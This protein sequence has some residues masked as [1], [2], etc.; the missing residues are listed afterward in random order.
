M[1]CATISIIAAVTLAGC[2]NR[3]ADLPLVEWRDAPGG[4]VVAFGPGNDN[5]RWAW[6]CF[7]EGDGNRCLSA[8]DLDDAMTFQVILQGEKPKL[9]QPPT[10]RRD[11]FGCSVTHTFIISQNILRDEATL[12]SEGMMPATRSHLP[13]KD[14]TI[15]FISE[16]VPNAEGQ[17]FD[18]ER[19][20][21]IFYRGSLETISTTLIA[22]NI[23]R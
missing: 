9:D 10:N 13:A 5:M 21:S 6:R 19:L 16:N 14:E 12:T 18:C 8:I 3:G 23:L 2:Q 17:Y 11:G 15:T 20:A 22:P 7:E 1:R 4:G